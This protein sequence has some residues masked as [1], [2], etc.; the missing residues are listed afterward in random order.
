M[1]N[2]SS[3]VKPTLGFWSLTSIGVGG[4]VGGGLFAVLGLTALLAK[5]ATPLAFILAGIVAFL[6]SYSYAKLSVAYPSQGGTV[7]F[8]NQ[9]F[10]PGLF[11]G[12]LNILLCLSYVIIV[13]LYAVG[14]ANYAMSLFPHADHLWKNII[15]SSVVVFLTLLN[16]TSPR[17]VIKSEL[18]FNIFKLVILAGFVIAGIW[19]VDLTRLEAPAW[20]SFPEILA[21]GMI[22]FL[23]YEGFELIANA[24]LAT[25][26]PEKNLPKAF[27]ASVLF[28]IGLYILISIV[29]IGNLPI[30]QFAQ[31]RDYAL[32]QSALPFFGN[33]GFILVSVAAVIASASAINAALYGSAKVTFIV[34]K[35]GE[36][37][38]FLD[39]MVVG[40]PIA[41]LLLLSA[42]VLIV[43]NFFNIESISMMASAGFLFIFAAVNAANF[44][45]AKETHANRLICAMGFTSCV[46]ATFAIILYKWNT[47]PI[48]I[49]ALLVLLLASFLIEL[50]YRKATGRRIKNFLH[51]KF[52][53]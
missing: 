25:K 45:L 13:A 23:S 33:G 53:P 32:A 18:F 40:K 29:A 41:G 15:L 3:S 7:V 38:T 34:A 47:D 36:L 14:L 31:A 49:L 37:P 44:K 16:M 8:L 52:K 17:M 39:R 12:G 1:N 50:I 22:I 26:K 21:G 2:T 43:G 42:L 19:T 27:Y 5:G 28:V 10:G 30:F 4:M 9:A 48:K 24:S 51:V 46:I 20:G 35:D 6:T 11:S